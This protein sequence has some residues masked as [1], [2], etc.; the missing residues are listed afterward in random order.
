MIELLGVTSSGIRL[1]NVVIGI[2]VRREHAADDNVSVASLV[3][4]DTGSQSADGVGLEL[5][6]A[7]RIVLRPDIAQRLLLGLADGGV[8]GQGAGHVLGIADVVGALF[9]GRLFGSV[10]GFRVGGLRRVVG[11]FRVSRSGGGI[12][13]LG[14]LVGGLGGAG[15][16]AEHH[17]QC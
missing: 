5:Q 16:K 8:N 17:D 4:A 2:A 13:G 9:T 10:G 15:D 7:V 6:R 1:Q 12:V 11:G 14:G 3:A